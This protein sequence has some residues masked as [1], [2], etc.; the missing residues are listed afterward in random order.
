[1][2]V[3]LMRLSV[4]IVIRQDLCVALLLAS[5]AS[6]ILYCACY[7]SSQPSEQ[8]AVRFT[9][10]SEDPFALVT[11]PADTRVQCGPYE[12]EF[13]RQEQPIGNI[14]LGCFLTLPP[15]PIPAQSRP[16]QSILISGGH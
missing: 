11:K 15:I 4:L 13:K 3:S 2:N 6:I 7:V 14:T 10:T 5:M 9:V 12:N 8:V 1:M 16:L